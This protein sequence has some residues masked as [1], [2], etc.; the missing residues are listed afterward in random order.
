MDGFRGDIFP[1]I[2]VFC[3]LCFFER[4]LFF[5]WF[6]WI[7]NQLAQH[8]VFW[9][10]LSR[11]VVVVKY[12]Y[13]RKGPKRTIF[14]THYVD[15]KATQEPA[16]CY[17]FSADCWCCWQKII[18][19]ECFIIQWGAEGSCIISPKLSISPSKGCVSEYLRLM[20]TISGDT[21]RITKSSHCLFRKEGGGKI[22]V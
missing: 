18:F 15:S 7:C 11:G 10:E 5:S 22:S 12:F 16:Y 6:C 14:A 1:K 21:L 8:G 13:V 3:S 2:H 19:K 9:I 4:V 17:H 20:N